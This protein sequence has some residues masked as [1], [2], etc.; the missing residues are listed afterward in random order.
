MGT[1]SREG[2]EETVPRFALLAARGRR[3]NGG[4][5]ELRRPGG[6]PPL[7]APQLLLLLLPLQLQGAVVP[8]LPPGPLLAAGA[9]TRRQEQ[10]CGS[11][12]FGMPHRDGAG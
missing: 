1:K 2:E 3:A 11:Y 7:P 9:G 8:G 5:Q 10:S 12:L 4:R 6:L